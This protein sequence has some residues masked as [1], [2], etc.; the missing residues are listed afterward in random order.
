LVHERGIKLVLMFLEGTHICAHQKAV[1]MG[2]WESD[3]ASCLQPP[4]R[5]IFC[6][7]RSPPASEPQRH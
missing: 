6:P 4:P 5:A 7:S 1:G 3:A 2:C